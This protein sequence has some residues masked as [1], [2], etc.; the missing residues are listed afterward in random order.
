MGF[1]ECLGFILRD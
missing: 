1:H